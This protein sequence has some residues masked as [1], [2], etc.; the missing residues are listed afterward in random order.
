MTYEE[1]CTCMVRYVFERNYEAYKNLPSRFKRNVMF[2][3]FDDLVSKPKVAVTKLARFIGTTK[4]IFTDEIIKKEN[5][6]RP[7]RNDHEEV[8]SKL[9]ANYHNK[10]LLLI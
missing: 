8:K 5:C 1:R 10:K 6:P 3:M 2:L 4:T 9:I 7:L